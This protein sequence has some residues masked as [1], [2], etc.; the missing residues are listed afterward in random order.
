MSEDRR[1]RC[2]SPGR[3]R[4]LGRR[5]P[6]PGAGLPPSIVRI[7]A[8]DAGIFGF[9]SRRNRRSGSS[10][11]SLAVADSELGHAFLRLFGSAQP[12]GHADEG[13]QRVL[14]THGAR[15]CR[16]SNSGDQRQYA[17]NAL[18]SFAKPFCFASSHMRTHAFSRAHQ[19]YPAEPMHPCASRSLPGM[20]TDAA[21][22]DEA[23]GAAAGLV[24]AADAGFATG[25]EDGSFSHATN[26]RAQA[27]RVLI[28]Q[29]FVTFTSIASSRRDCPRVPQNA[30]FITG[31]RSPRSCR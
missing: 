21:G 30:P 7:A 23:G 25:A 20:G 28:G 18:G 27:M 22:A 5:Q 17:A 31:P 10:I 6:V 11:A 29:R 12:F 1:I 14:S 4:A 2:P 19:R 15:R 24:G 3:A 26:A 13:R 16:R 9:R 8:R